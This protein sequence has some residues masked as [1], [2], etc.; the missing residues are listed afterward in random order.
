[1]FQPATV[2]AALVVGA[3]CMILVERR[4]ERPTCVSLD[5]LTPRMA[6][7]IGC[8]QCLALWPGFSRSAATIMGGMILGARRA[9]AAEYSF[10]AAVPIMMAATGYDLLKNFSLFTAAD[11]PFFAVGMVG[12]F[13]SALLAVKAFVALVG[14]MTLVPFAIYRLALAPFVYYFVVR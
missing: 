13:V 4:H 11:I 7:G 8:F 1:L 3:I 6:L 12:A 2:L 9:L 5:E 14:K 10:I